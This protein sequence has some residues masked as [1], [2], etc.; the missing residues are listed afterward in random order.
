MDDS[1]ADA[2]VM[3]PSGIPEVM[4]KCISNTK[5]FAS[6]V[7]SIYIL[8][9]A[10]GPLMITPVTGPYGRSVVYLTCNVMFMS[11]T[12]TCAVA[13]NFKLL[14]RSPISEGTI[15]P[16]PLTAADETIAN[17][18]IQQKSSSVM[19]VWLWAHRI[20]RVIAEYL[21]KVIG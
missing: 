6:F 2:G 1:C 9:D 4:F 10:F 19:A 14:T 15:G 18:I 3:Q 12:I 16:A 11:F 13:S 17:R 20:G 5:G 21:A 7:A 8:G